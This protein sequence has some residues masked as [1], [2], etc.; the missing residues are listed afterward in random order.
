MTDDAKT[1]RA[2][3]K[4][5]EARARALGLWYKKKRF[6][7]GGCLLVVILIAVIA[8]A[9]GD[10]TSKTGDSSKNEDSKSAYGTT[11]GPD[12]PARDGKF[13]SG[14]TS[15]GETSS[16]GTS[17]GNGESASRVTDPPDDRIASTVTITFTFKVTGPTS[18]QCSLKLPKGSDG[19]GVLDAAVAQGCI[20]SYQTS[21]S[22]N[23][24]PKGGPQYP[25]HHWLRCIDS[26]CDVSYGSPGLA[27]ETRWNVSWQGERGAYM[28]SGLEG[29]AAVNGDTVVCELGAVN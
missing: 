23:P 24:P 16:G 9:G 12:E 1:A 11:V 15:S 17:S 20:R 21:E 3:A 4:A 14:G 2:E 7:L 10:K 29:Y 19:I 28:S 5:P 8:S 22:P 6:I 27:P 18:K 13:E 26:D 25:G